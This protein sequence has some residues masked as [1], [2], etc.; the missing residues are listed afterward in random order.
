[1]ARDRYYTEALWGPV[2]VEPESWLDV[3]Y[4]EDV[5]DLPATGHNAAEVY[6][7]SAFPR[8]GDDAEAQ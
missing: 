5:N 8:G 4:P 7:L 1:M 6:S 3:M 2:H